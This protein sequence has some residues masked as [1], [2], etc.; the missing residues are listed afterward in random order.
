M[1]FGSKRVIRRMFRGQVFYLLTSYDCESIS[2]CIAMAYGRGQI[3]GQ[4]K[5]ALVE[6]VLVVDG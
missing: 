3:Y 5:N 6:S 2:A 1:V 4:N